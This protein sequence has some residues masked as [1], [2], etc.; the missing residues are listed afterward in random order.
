[1]KDK[2]KNIVI[3][4]LLLVIVSGGYWV[5]NYTSNVKDALNSSIYSSLK[6][7]QKQ[8]VSLRAEL[9]QYDGKQMSLEEFNNIIHEY[10][11]NYFF[12]NEFI[13]DYKDID[14]SYNYLDFSDLNSYILSLYC[15]EIPVED[16]EYHKE[17]IAKICMYWNSLN[18]TRHAD[19]SHPNPQLKQTLKKIHRLSQDG[20]KRIEK[21]DQYN[22]KL[23]SSEQETDEAVKV[24]NTGV[25]KSLTEVSNNI[26]FSKDEI[27]SG[28]V[29]A[30]A[31][32]GSLNYTLAPEEVEEFIEA[33]NSY[34]ITEADRK[35]ISGNHTA[36][37]DSINVVLKMDNGEKAFYTAFFNGEIYV[38]DK[39]G[40]FY[41]LYNEDLLNYILSLKKHLYPDAN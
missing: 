14:E 28:E 29:S 25:D 35:E 5:R 10:C 19:Y 18:F 21:A 30:F 26:T 2:S 20:K 36:Q 32:S 11:F 37:S 17:N 4:V 40:D 24:G 13:G 34:N 3:V 23:Q 12:Y 41:S 38:T 16:M 27:I 8:S 1:M 33:F 7:T 6:I 31:V 9:K 39:N 15:T 22:L